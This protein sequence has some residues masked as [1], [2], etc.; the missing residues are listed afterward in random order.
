MSTSWKTSVAGLCSDAWDLSPIRTQRVIDELE[1]LIATD[2]LSDLA[3]AGVLLAVGM[4]DPNAGAAA[5][6]IRATIGHTRT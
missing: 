2:Q 6:S 3:V 4:R 1:V 5:R